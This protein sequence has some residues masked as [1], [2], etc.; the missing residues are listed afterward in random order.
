[1][2][3]EELEADKTYVFKDDALRYVYLKSHDCNSSYLYGLYENGFKL[4][5]ASSI[6]GGYIGS[7]KVID[8]DEIHLFKEKESKPFDI[9]EY[10]F[11]DDGLRFEVKDMMVFKYKDWGDHQDGVEEELFFAFNKQDAE[12]IA[13]HFKLI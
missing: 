8:I 2:K 6:R 7:H 12:A 1:M 11:S 5:Y 10:E 4:S 3:L 9:S 13:K